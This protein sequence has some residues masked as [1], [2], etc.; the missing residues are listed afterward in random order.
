MS[1]A[2]QH[3]KVSH[4]VVHSCFHMYCIA[5]GARRIRC[6]R[7]S[8]RQ[9]H[10]CNCCPQILTDFYRASLSP[11]SSLSSWRVD[12]CGP[13]RRLST[14]STFLRALLHLSLAGRS[15]LANLLYP[16]L[17]RTSRGSLPVRARTMTTRIQCELMLIGWLA[18][19]YLWRFELFECSTAVWMFVQVI[20]SSKNWW[21]VQNHAS[22]TGFVPN[23][24][25]KP[26]SAE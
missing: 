21:K 16:C 14:M 12:S 15:S 5:G 11:S 8:C 20:D 23:T 2:L 26:F 13:L 9:M 24:I 7:T 6:E 22:A 25:L 19:L 10:E 1:S 3:C 17:S 18:H 4:G